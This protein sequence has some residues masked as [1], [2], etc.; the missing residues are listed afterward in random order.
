M[1]E[2]ACL[3]TPLPPGEEKDSK[4]SM[5]ADLPYLPIDPKR[6][7]PPIGLIGCGMVT[8]FHLKAYAAAGYDVVALC[9][10]DHAKATARQQAFYPQARIYGDH[11]ELLKR[12]DIEVVD[13]ATHPSE[14]V[15]LMEDALHAGKHVLSQKPF[16]L[17]LDQGERLCDLADRVN[18]RLAVNQNGRWAPHFS[19]LRLPA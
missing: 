6:Y 1:R 9:D 2:R 14:R 11:R 10:C 5:A 7:R 3:C 15:T 4:S 19:Y 13:I 18:R 12:D 8:E 17:D 16:V